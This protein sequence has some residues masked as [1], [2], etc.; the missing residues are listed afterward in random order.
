MLALAFLLSS[1][2]ELLLNEAA[3]LPPNRGS[4]SVAEF[5]ENYNMLQK[6]YGVNRPVNTRTSIFTILMPNRCCWMKTG[7]GRSSPN[8]SQ[9]YDETFSGLPQLIFDGNEKDITGV[10]FSLSYNNENVTVMPYDDFM[11]LQLC[12]Y[13]CAG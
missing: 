3:S 4:L 5:C 6:F 9:S 13:L 7:S 8:Y 10:S 1:G 12:P 2:S 11:A